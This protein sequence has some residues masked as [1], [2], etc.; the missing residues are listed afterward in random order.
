MGSDDGRLQVL[1][2]IAARF[3]HSAVECPD[4]A[5]LRKLQ[6]LHPGI[7]LRGVRVLRI[8]GIIDYD[9]DDESANST[10]DPSISRGVNQGE[11]V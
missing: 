6:Q 11:E 1:R 9:H 2:W 7:P 4:H 8:I 3:A 10:A 5:L